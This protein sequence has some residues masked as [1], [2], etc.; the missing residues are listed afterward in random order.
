MLLRCHLIQV[1]ADYRDLLFLHRDYDV[2]FGADC[3]VVLL[4]PHVV[5]GKDGYVE[6]DLDPY[7]PVA[8]D[9]HTR[10]PVE[11]RGG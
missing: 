6:V 5:D 7:V 1:A 8:I 3:R 10:P 4:L 9:R 11:P 2:Q